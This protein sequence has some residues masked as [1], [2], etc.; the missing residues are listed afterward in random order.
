[1]L[2]HVC[3]LL[4]VDLNHCAYGLSSIRPVEYVYVCTHVCMC[5]QYPEV[6]ISYFFLCLLLN[7]NF[8]RQG[9]LVNLGCVH[10][11]RLA[12]QQLWRPISSPALGLQGHTAG[13]AS[14]VS[15]GAVNSGPHTYVAGTPLSHLPIGALEHL[16][17]TCDVSCFSTALQRATMA[18][19]MLYHLRSLGGIV[20]C[21]SRASKLPEFAFLEMEF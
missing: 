15:A 9:L 16:S 8:L 6:D 4:H 2:N 18:R 21:V 10:Y 19:G 13:S 14:S 3:P 17:I 12:G 20:T 1:M 5:V 7:L 11:S